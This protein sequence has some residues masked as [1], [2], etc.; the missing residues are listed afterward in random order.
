MGEGDEILH[1]VKDIREQMSVLTTVEKQVNTN[2]TQIEQ[3]TNALSGNTTMGLSGIASRL[4]RLETDVAQIQEISQEFKSLKQGMARLQEAIEMSSKG[5]KFTNDHDEKIDK[6]W[7]GYQTVL[8]I[9]KF[10]SLKTVQGWAA[11]FI[12]CSTIVWLLAQAGLVSF[13]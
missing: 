3:L 12:F 9:I 13:P 10:F 5:P 11:L 1:V 2:S 4:S 6:M 7:E 8:M